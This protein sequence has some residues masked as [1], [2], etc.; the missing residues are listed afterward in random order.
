M[1]LAYIF[2]NYN[3]SNFTNS[4]VKSIASQIS[5]TVN[6]LVVIVD[7]CSNEEDKISL[8]QIANEFSIIKLIFNSENIGYFK[9]LNVGLKYIKENH[10]EINYCIVGNNDL[11]F[12]QTFT[13]QLLKSL[14]L[15]KHYPVI[16][17]DII[18]YD[19]EHQNP[20]V[21]N[22]ISKLRGLI[23]D[24]YYTNYNLSK[25][26][27]MLSKILKKF[28]DR[29]DEKY[30]NIPSE[31]YQGHGSCYILGPLFLNNFEELFAP[32][33]LMSEE[34]FLAYQLKLK[35]YR[36]YYT[37]LIK[38]THFGHASLKNVPSKYIWKISRESHKIY[39]K[40]LNLYN[41]I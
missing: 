15:F 23:F 16:S 12:P 17:P 7:N 21:L 9:G 40:Y 19:G 3:N 38:V 35:G 28:T 32:T 39:K 33:F 4:V 34:F 22:K 30:H 41:K 2:T 31:I 13:D 24:L 8:T 18:T 20:H 36:I 37:P 11:E 27:L 1:T 25:L 26:I 5:I 10:P 14:K 29:N 6:T